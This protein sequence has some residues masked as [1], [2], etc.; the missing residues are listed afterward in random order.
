MVARMGAI[1]RW[2]LLVIVGVGFLSAFVAVLFEPFASEV[3]LRLGVDS[4]KWAGPVLSFLMENWPVAIIIFVCG[5]AAGAWAHFA[6]TK[7]DRRGQVSAINRPDTRL[8]LKIDSSGSMNFIEEY[9]ANVSHWQQSIVR[10][11]PVSDDSP[12]IVHA[13]IL[14]LAFDVPIEHERPIVEAKGGDLKGYNFYS[15]GTRGAVFQFFGV[16]QASE[17][18]I[19]FPPFGYYA[20]RS[21]LNRDRLSPRQPK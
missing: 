19:W 3:L 15:L 16:I 9:Q 6:I 8:R 2:F 12:P 13:D 5:L 17:L 7:I 20:Q 21:D 11:A 18:D 14:S 1:F 10:V 4:S